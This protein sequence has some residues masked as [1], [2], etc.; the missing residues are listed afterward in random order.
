M[1]N[2]ESKP[3]ISKLLIFV[4]ILIWFVGFTYPTGFGQSYNVFETAKKVTVVVFLA[5]IIFNNEN[6]HLTTKI[7]LATIII[8]CITVINVIRN[9]K[10]IEDYIWVWLLI[11]IM[12]SFGLEKSQM[13]KIGYIFGGMSTAVLL[14]GNFTD[15]FDGWDGNS[16][17]MV[18][19]F[20][21]TVFMS[22]FT[23]V[24]DIKNIR[25]IVVFS[26]VY[27]YLLNKFDSRSAL[28][29]SIVMLL[30][31]LSVI[32]FKKFLS[33]T[34]IYLILL[35]PLLIAIFVM[36]INETALADILNEWSIE[37][38]N[39]PI[40]NGRDV[41]WEWGIEAW[42]ESP[43]IGNGDF[44]HESYHNSAITTIVAVGAFGYLILIGACYGIIRRALRWIDDSVIYGLI[45]SFLVVWMQ[46][47]VELGII[48]SKPNV[49]PYL[50]LGLIY[51]RTITLE[52]KNNDTL[53]D[54]NADLQYWEIS[55]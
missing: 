35:S 7:A 50:I 23:E 16:V 19:F 42:L 1:E 27:F 37:T 41:L 2:T 32:P 9:D 51:A 40:F 45:T 46:Q 44:A 34:F 49:I 17:S 29:F 15:T 36:S 20:S 8:A 53:V 26:A 24:R 11:P 3:F 25:N 52:E 31:T 18:Q 12:K 5:C 48:A 47:S 30:C 28:L 4:C 43:F 21:Y 33:K 10:S 55:S 38:F 39:K 6:Y 22:I 54:N 13:K 14:I